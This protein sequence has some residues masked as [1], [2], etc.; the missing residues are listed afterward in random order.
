M[1]KFILFSFISALI[2]LLLSCKKNHDNAPTPQDQNETELITTVSLII[3]ENGT[4][5]NT[6]TFND[7]DGAGGVNPIVDQITL[8]ANKTYTCTLRLLD[9]TKNPTDTTSLEIEE[10]KD[11]H[12]FFFHPSA[13]TNMS[14]AY[15]DYDDHHVPVG[16][17]STITTGAAGTGTLRVVLKHQPGLKPT[18]GNGDEAL[19]ETD[20]EVSFDVTIQ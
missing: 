9:E 15:V 12:Q 14:F 3:K 6:F 2:M 7:P 11:V 10:E 20:M 5:V 18:S 13:G 19:G 4:P 8:E 17:Q 1:K 16:L